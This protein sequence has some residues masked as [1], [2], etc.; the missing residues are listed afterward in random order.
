MTRSSRKNRPIYNLVAKNPVAR[1]YYTGNHEHPVRRTVLIINETDEVLIGYE[2][3]EGSAVRSHEDALK[4]IK[5]Y[6]KDSIARWGD[7]SR[8]RMSTKNFL[9]N[10]KA[11][12]LERSPILTMFTEGA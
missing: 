8:L 10:P 5:T 4:E 1:F 11:S 9:K 7:Y 6:R 3:R 2:F 12:T